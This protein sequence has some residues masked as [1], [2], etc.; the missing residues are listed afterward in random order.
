MGGGSS[1][2]RRASRRAAEDKPTESVSTNSNYMQKLSTENHRHLGESGQSLAHFPR[3][4]SKDIFLAAFA[5]TIEYLAIQ[6]GQHWLKWGGAALFWY[7]VRGYTRQ[8]KIVAR[9][10]I[11]SIAAIALFLGAYGLG[12]D[13]I[14]HANVSLAIINI[15]PVSST[16][17]EVLCENDS[18]YPANNELCWTGIFFEPTTD[19][20]VPLDEQERAFSSS[21]TSLQLK[22]PTTAPRTLEP[23]GKRMAVLE[24]TNITQEGWDQ[25]ESR[26]G[27]FL[28]TGIIIWKDEA[29]SH[30]TEFCKWRD[31]QTTAE[32]Q[33]GGNFYRLCK[34]H[35][36]IVY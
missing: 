34:E 21:E 5:M 16:P 27:T 20:T 24:N 9:C 3:G 6:Y 12:K 15:S 28:F 29:G 13:R 25:V 35:N 23:H 32:G 10:I 31:Y 17:F 26:R 8:K 19:G 1:H 36:G 22:Y 18:D 2:D 11:N 33:T 30:R 7:A 4:Q 14:N